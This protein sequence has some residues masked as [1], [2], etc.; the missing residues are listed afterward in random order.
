[1]AA[2]KCK[3]FYFLFLPPVSPF[4]RSRAGADGNLHA[5]GGQIE[6]FAAANFFFTSEQRCFVP[7]AREGDS[8]RQKVWLNS[9]L[10]ADLFPPSTFPSVKSSIMEKKW[11]FYTTCEVRYVKQ[12]SRNEKPSDASAMKK[13]RALFCL[14]RLVSQFVL[15]FVFNVFFSFFEAGN[16]SSL[17]RFEVAQ[18]QWSHCDICLMM[19]IRI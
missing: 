6:T 13:N 3:F 9:S 10:F 19:L 7:F 11:P 5:F 1:M 15:L 18:S 4:L 8:N 17:K 12:F 2:Q 16:K 14:S